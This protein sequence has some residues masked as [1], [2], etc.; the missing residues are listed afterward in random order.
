MISFVGKTVD[1]E[2]S[3]HI[4]YTDDNGTTFFVKHGGKRVI[5]TNTSLPKKLVFAIPGKTNY[6]DWFMKT[7]ETTQYPDKVRLLW[8]PLKPN[9]QVKGYFNKD[10]FVVTHIKTNQLI[11]YG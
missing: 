7:T 1:K 9:L 2:E 11:K 3:Y 4:V 5:I 10:G 8:A 6:N